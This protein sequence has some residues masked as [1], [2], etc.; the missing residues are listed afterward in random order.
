MLHKYLLLF[1]TSLRIVKQDTVVESLEETLAQHKRALPAFHKSLR[2]VAEIKVA[3]EKGNAKGEDGVELGI[4]EIRGFVNFKDLI[5]DMEARQYV[6]EC[7]SNC[8]SNN[9]K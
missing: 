1:G 6:Y 2:N 4:K 3:F 5:D 8:V 9:F 7:P